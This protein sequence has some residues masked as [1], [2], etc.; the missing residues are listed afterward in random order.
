MN[1]ISAVNLAVKWKTNQSAIT[2]I[3]YYIQQIFNQYQDIDNKI[4]KTLAENEIKIFSEINKLDEKQNNLSEIFLQSNEKV[5]IKII[6][7]EAEIR[8]FP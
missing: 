2:N 6:K 8:N 7:I 3:N 1:Q 4:E 5:F